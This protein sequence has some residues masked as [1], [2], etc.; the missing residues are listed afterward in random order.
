MIQL[1][2]EAKRNLKQRIAKIGPYSQFKKAQ[3]KALNKIGNQLR[4]ETRAAWANA[5]YKR[6]KRRNSVRSAIVRSIKPQIKSF[7]R[8]VLRLVVGASVRTNIK[9]MLVNVLDPGFTP[10]G[11]RK[12]FGLFRKV[13]GFKIK[14]KMQA[15]AKQLIKTFPTDLRRELAAILMV[16]P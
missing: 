8:D 16:Q 2:P 6:K 9:A 13:K 3:R 14:Q 1:T 15:R 12:R 4:K 7:G 11:S 5:P 10:R